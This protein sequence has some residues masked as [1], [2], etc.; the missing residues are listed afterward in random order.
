MSAFSQ[1]NSHEGIVFIDC[2]AIYCLSSNKVIKLSRANRRCKHCDLLRLVW[3]LPCFTLSKCG[4]PVEQTIIIHVMSVLE[5]IWRN[6]KFKILLL[7]STLSLNWT[8]FVVLLNWM[9]WRILLHSES[10]RSLTQSS[11]WGS[12]RSH[13]KSL[14]VTV[15]Q[16][17]LKSAH[18]LVLVSICVWN[19]IVCPYLSGLSLESLDIFLMVLTS[20]LVELLI[21]P[22][23][24]ILVEDNLLLVSFL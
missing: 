15:V 23:W 19:L 4:H 2:A 18:K 8:K 22:H 10:I 14:L 12:C 6:N 7:V 5:L 17:S 21:W 20:F 11:A 16:V 9:C 1:V 13:H 3:I 24:H